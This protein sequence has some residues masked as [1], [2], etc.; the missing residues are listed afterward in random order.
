[1]QNC[2]GKRNLFSLVNSS[3]E[4]YPDTC[5]PIFC[6]QNHLEVENFEKYSLETKANRLTRR[7]P[8]VQYVCITLV[9]NIGITYKGYLVN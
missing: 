1:M 4:I 3:P 7:R 9:G 6:T 2:A 5:H 8:R